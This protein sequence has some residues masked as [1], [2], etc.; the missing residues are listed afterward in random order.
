[1]NLDRFRISIKIWIPVISLAVFTLALVGYEL[2]SLRSVLYAERIA[3]TETI[4]EVTNSV[5]TYF[6]ELEKSGELTREQ[7]QTQARDV[8]RAIRYDGSNYAFVFDE[9]G[10]RL[11]SSNKATEGNNAWDSKDKTGKFHVREM[12]ETAK[13]GGGVVSYMWNRKGEEA[14]LPKASWAAPFQPWG[15]VVATGI[16][17]DDV[18]AAFWSQA[19]ELLGFL[20]VGGLVVAFIATAAIR[21]MAG[22]LKTLTQSMK[23]LADGD[24]DIAIDGVNRGDEIGEMA[25]AMETF[26]ANA[27]ARRELESQHSE[28]QELDIQRSRNIQGLSSNF[29]VK[30]SGLLETITASVESLQSASTSLNAGAQQT[31]SQSDAVKG[32]A[33]SASANTETVAAA[34]EELAASVTEIG[35]QVSSSSE[36]ASQAASQA[37][38]T[39]HR[40]QGLSAAAGK[41]GE[42]VTLIQAIA[43]QTNLLALNA[44]IEAA[45]AGEAGKGFAV[46]AAEVKELA[47]QTSKATEEISSQ[48]S[49]IQ[50]E[51]SQAVDAIAAI[52]DTVGKINDITSSITAA[53]EEQGAATQEIASNI[54][55][56]ASGTQ[57]VSA[58][59]AGVSEAASVTNE[60]AD[61]VFNAS[62]SLE[63][64]ARELREQVGAFLSGIKENASAEAA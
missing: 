49:S 43:E 46:V 35:R 5:A 22:P 32:A 24:T 58:N 28:R 54:Q 52:T 23:R 3:K 30:V 37:A 12:I 33:A 64:E 20:L 27:N 31:T 9:E 51:T 36:I 6:H 40:I 1:M 21:N 4:V 11:V 7:A 47:T 39:N 61:L 57:E 53:V 29:D 60:A 15:W 10:Q 34:A 45:R 38:E 2:L 14:L 8:I 63:S 25:D 16:Y 18:A 19:L 62:R 17:V 41:I 26:V 48:I 56:A 55:Q 13:A 59:I 42:V 50:G 44:T